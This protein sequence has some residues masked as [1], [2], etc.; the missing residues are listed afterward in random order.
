MYFENGYFLQ[1][2]YGILY[3]DNKEIYCGE[4]SYNKPKE[5]KNLTIYDT[6]G[7]K[8]YK[9][10]FLDFKYHGEGTLYF[11]NSNKNFFLRNF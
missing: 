6:K 7:N 11:E 10:D 9:G 1:K 3:E 5:G 2:G 8:I 4:L